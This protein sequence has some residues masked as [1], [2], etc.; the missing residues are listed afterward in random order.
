[1]KRNFLKEGLE[2]IRPELNELIGLLSIKEL[3][4]NFRFIDQYQK[5]HMDYIRI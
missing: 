5:L 4:T 2:K 1:M 3:T